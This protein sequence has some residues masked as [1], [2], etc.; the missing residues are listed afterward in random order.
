M[1]SPSSSPS[2]P[3]GYLTRISLEAVL[4]VPVVACLMAGVVSAAFPDRADGATRCPVTTPNGAQLPDGYGSPPSNKGAPPNGGGRI[5]GNGEVWSWLPQDG[6]YV[7]SGPQVHPDGSV[8]IKWY[9]WRRT[10]TPDASRPTF[11]GEMRITGHRLDSPAEDFV[12]RVHKHNT[13]TFQGATIVFPSAGCW[14]IVG[15]SGAEPL[16]FVVLLLVADDTMPNA[17]MAPNDAGELGLPLAALVSGIVLASAGYRLNR[18]GIRGFDFL[19][20][21]ISSLPTRLRR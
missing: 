21:P 15:S 9:W 4:S 12:G 14:E 1:A 3:T 8:E 7:A 5:H 18:R 20:R 19:I 6:I 13:G 10:E 2:S 17:A 11:P 16:T